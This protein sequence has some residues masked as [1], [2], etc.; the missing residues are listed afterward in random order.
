[1]TESHD[2]A[3]C[4]RAL[5]VHAQW[6]KVVKKIII[7]LHAA[8]DL[9]AGFVTKSRSEEQSKLAPCIIYYYKVCANNIIIVR[10]ARYLPFHH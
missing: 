10:N 9:C 2:Q 6:V 5:C 7:M 4:A 1:V 3:G 8:Q